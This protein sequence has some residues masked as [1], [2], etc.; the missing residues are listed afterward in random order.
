[1]ERI[2]TMIS[3]CNDGRTGIY[4]GVFD[5]P[6]NGHFHMIKKAR[7]IFDQVIVI[8][9]SNPSK[10]T[11]FSVDDRMLML[12]TMIAGMYNVKVDTLPSNE[13]LVSYAKRKYQNISLIRGIRDNID[14]SY[15]QNI[16]RTNKKIDPEVETIY[17]MPDDSH[18]LVSSSWVKG[19]IGMAGWR[20]VIKDSVSP[21]VLKVLKERYLKGEM[22]KILLAHPFKFL[23]EKF[24][25]EK[26]LDGYASNSYHNFDHILDGLDAFQMYYPEASPVTLFAWLMHDINPDEDKS[27]EI[28]NEFLGPTE[29][30]MKNIHC[31]G[32]LDQIKSS[33]A[34]VKRLIS[35]TKHKICDYETEEEAI[36]ASID[37]L[38]LSL[39]KTEYM[40]Y[41]ER[42]YDEYWKK[43]GLPILE[44]R[45][46]WV[47]GRS[48][49][50]SQM[51]GRKYIYPWPIIRERAFVQQFP[52][53][54]E[55]TSLEEQARR[56]LFDEKGKLL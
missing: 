11:M 25:W 16:C 13:Y 27:I 34:L 29:E 31:Y 12:Q 43:S 45:K 46:K 24:M 54:D 4:A 56:N 18:S 40:G 2:E 20:N 26:M 51:L 38:C 37:L 22:D 42:V 14:F 48:A 28:A 32:I 3:N 7:Y 55:P 10:N 1:M 49:F 39:P 52:T 17:L 6:T 47:E 35:A 5:P 19:L 23:P 8:I 15:E 9:A 44:F 21:F 36:F 41:C 33:K 53:P 50:I 30:E